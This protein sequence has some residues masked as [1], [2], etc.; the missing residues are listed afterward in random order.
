MLHLI[1]CW[2]SYRKF[3]GNLPKCRNFGVSYETS[4]FLYLLAP[5]YFYADTERSVSRHID[6]RNRINLIFLIIGIVPTSILVRY[7]PATPSLRLPED[8]RT[9]YSFF[10]YLIPPLHFSRCSH[11]FF[12]FFRKCQE[13]ASSAATKCLCQRRKIHATPLPRHRRRPPLRRTNRRGNWRT[14]QR[15]NLGINRRTNRRSRHRRRQCLCP[16]V[17][18][19]P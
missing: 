6:C 2:I 9:R 7:P 19:R 18:R 5:T 15:T 11:F 8:T 4:C 17:F 1:Y 13:L 10:M 12:V 14:N 16:T 3:E